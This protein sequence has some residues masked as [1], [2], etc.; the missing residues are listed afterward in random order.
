[1]STARRTIEF[2]DRH[3]DLLDYCIFDS[4]NATY[5]FDY[6][7]LSPNVLTIPKILNLEIGAYLYS[8]NIQ[9]VIDSFE[10]INGQTAISYYPLLK[11]LDVNVYHDRTI[12]SASLLNF[13]KMLIEDNLINNSDDTQNVYGMNV[14]IDQHTH[15]HF[16]A[17]L[18]I[19][20]NIN[21]I[22]TLLTKALKKYNLII[23]SELVP[24]DKKINMVISIC[25]DYHRIKAKQPY[26]IDYD[27]YIKPENNGINKF[28]AVWKNDETKV[29]TFYKNSAQ[30]YSKFT[31]E[32]IEAMEYE[33]FLTA[34]KDRANDLFAYNDT[35]NY[36]S[37]TVFKKSNLYKDF[38][39][40]EIGLIEHEDKTYQAILTKIS[41][42]SEVIEYVFGSIRLDLTDK[43]LLGGL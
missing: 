13:F 43:L 23:V 7:T 42:Q 20:D 25:E 40:G 36:I 26:V 5:E 29:E 30:E 1:M 33:E 22:Y 8:N 18:N 12:L 37:I 27:I 38:K 16:N 35:S 28:I 11:L 14:S 9:G 10:Y 21:N 19:V 24:S 3:F 31:T 34:A 17:A 2:Y 4:E 41:M 6:M 32:Y 15:D 39:I